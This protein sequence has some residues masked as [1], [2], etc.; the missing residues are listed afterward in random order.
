MKEQFRNL[1]RFN[2]ELK[3]IDGGVSLR[4]GSKFKPGG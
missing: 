3:R 2:F 4:I 1:S